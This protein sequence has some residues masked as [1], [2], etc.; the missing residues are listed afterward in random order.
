[1]TPDRAELLAAVLRERYGPLEALLAEGRRGGVAIGSH[2]R[3][4]VTSPTK[5]NGPG[6]LRQEPR[7]VSYDHPER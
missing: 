7:T 5:R 4:V 2:G 3:K 6:R 1:M